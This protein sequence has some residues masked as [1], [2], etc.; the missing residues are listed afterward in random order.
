MVMGSDT[1]CWNLTNSADVVLIGGGEGTSVPDFTGLVPGIYILSLRCSDCPPVSTSIVIPDN[2]HPV[3]ILTTQIDYCSNFQLDLT[4]PVSTYLWT[5]MDPQVQILSATSGK[6]LIQTDLIQGYLSLTITSGTCSTSQPILFYFDTDPATIQIS[7]GTCG[8]SISLTN[9]GSQICS[10][11]DTSFTGCQREEMN[12]GT[13]E[14][15]YCDTCG[16]IRTSSFS[17]VSSCLDLCPSDPFKIVPGQCGCG[18]PDLDE[19]RDGVAA[20][21][22]EC[23][24][25]CQTI[26]PCPNVTFISGPVEVVISAGELDVKLT[27]DNTII[28][29]EHQSLVEIDSQEQ[30][31][32]LLSLE[33]IP[34]SQR[35]IRYPGFR[36]LE[37]RGQATLKDQ[38]VNLTWYYYFFDAYCTYAL[39]GVGLDLTSLKCSNTSFDSSAPTQTYVQ[40]GDSKISFVI[41]NWSFLDDSHRLKAEL[42]YNISESSSEFSLL[43]STD[44]T[45]VYAY[46]LSASLTLQSTYLTQCILDGT[47]TQVELQLNSLSSVQVIF[48]HFTNSVAYDPLLSF[49]FASALIDT[50]SW[51]HFQAPLIAAGMALLVIIAFIGLY[52]T[53]HGYV[54]LAGEEAARVKDLRGFQ[55]ENSHEIELQDKI[56]R[57]MSMMAREDDV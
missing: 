26:G 40:P 44:S 46:Q 8:A 6:P 29:L 43:K 24:T 5:T 39:E 53:D 19:D 34:W 32:Q 54:L 33:D 1:T 38:L 45:Q 50:S 27:V 10:W 42:I 18:V 48:P 2:I 16:L 52:F 13:Y 56:S 30:E 31:I 47:A 51:F 17:V 25:N 49:L 15:T 12:T 35:L 22:D 28:I 4:G 20:C 37:C 36:L 21:L 55:R 11:S 3:A 9:L 41:S 23:D 14:V 57:E 7:N